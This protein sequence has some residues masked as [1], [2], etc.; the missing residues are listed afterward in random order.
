MNAEYCK[1]SLR[2]LTGRESRTGYHPA[3]LRTLFGSTRV[4]PRLPFSRS[5][6]F[7]ESPRYVRGLS[8]SGMQQKLSLKVDDHHR[9][10]ITAEGGQYILKPSPEAYPRA[11]ENEHGAMTVSRMLGIDT[12]QCGLVRFT[13]G[14]LAYLSKRF[15]RRAEGGK[16]HQEDLLQCFGQSAEDKY[17]RTYEEAGRQVHKVTNGKLAVVLDFLRR[18]LLAWV[19][20]NDDLHLKNFS[21][22]RLPKNTSRYYDVLTPAYDCLFC[23]ALGSAEQQY[24]GRDSLALGLLHD[25]KDGG[26]YLTGV[27]QHY[28]YY[29]GHDFLE[30]GRRLGLPE[31]PV[32]TFIAKLVHN[33]QE[34]IDIIKHSYMPDDMKTRAA[35]TVAGRIQALQVLAAA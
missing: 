13:D 8:I 14:E 23:D 11:A 27:Y 12:A 16:L 22:Q 7:Q 6:F 3:A 33:Q 17:G 29:T 10:A 35:G 18:V 2:K 15:D 1:I 4:D 28:G 19:T 21:V 30:L 5:E 25:P 9:L 31:K 32:L 34:I 26:E 20:G 24:R